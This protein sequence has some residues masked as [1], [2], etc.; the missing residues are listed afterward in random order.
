MA[1]HVAAAPV[2]E[3][4][5]RGGEEDRE[6]ELPLRE[7]SR[8]N[9]LPCIAV[10]IGGPWIEGQLL[11]WRARFRILVGSGRLLA[12]SELMLRG[13]CRT[14]GKRSHGGKNGLLGLVTCGA[15]IC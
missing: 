4:P 7:V 5:G 14:Q 11:G 2:Q 10:L 9:V 12:W 3:D 13:L 6:E 15:E 1:V 8:G